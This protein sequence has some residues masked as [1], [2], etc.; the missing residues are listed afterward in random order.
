MPANQAGQ[1]KNPNYIVTLKTAE[2][3]DKE[4][5]YLNIEGYLPESLA[6]NLTASWD[7]VLKDF[8]SGADLTKA[9]GW[10]GALAS[11]V[12][13]I[14][15]LLGTKTAYSQ[16]STY[17]TWTG[18][19]PLQFSIPFRFDAVNDTNNDVVEPWVNLMKL[20]CPTK[21]GDLLRAPGPS[22]TLD[23]ETK[24]PLF[25]K[26][27][28]LSL[29]IGKFIYIRGVIVTSVSNTLFSKF[30]VKGRPIQA[31]ADVTLRTIFSPTVTDIENWFSYNENYGSFETDFNKATESISAEIKKS[32]LGNAVLN[33]LGKTQEVKQDV[34]ASQNTTPWFDKPSS[35]VLYKSNTNSSVLDNY[36]NYSYKL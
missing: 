25:N 24:T 33:K 20:V 32:R 31:E 6:I 30:D 5:G 3:K 21:N 14:M 16:L 17:P 4:E 36:T 22:I 23:E 27:R 18:T 7:S 13:T 1:Y 9:G 10:T 8:L 28:V 29:S 26:S 34:Q 11:G 2:I 12:N 19:E 35:S 15:D